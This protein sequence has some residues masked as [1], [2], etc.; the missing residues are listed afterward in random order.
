MKFVGLG[1][2]RKARMSRETLTAFN[3]SQAIIEFAPNGTI[4]EANENFCQVMG[5]S[6]DEIVGGHHRMFADPAYA[7]SPEYQQFWDRLNH[8]E[9]SAGEYM[10]LG[11]GGKK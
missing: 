1:G 10:R 3:K 2:A 7:A 8:G 9:F 11:K 6:L 4:L 5:Y